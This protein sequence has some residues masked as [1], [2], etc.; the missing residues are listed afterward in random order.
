MKSVHRRILFAFLCVCL[1]SP[2]LIAQDLAQ[3]ASRVSELWQFRQQGNRV[4]TL[5]LIE[6]QTQNEFLQANDSPIISFKISAIEFTD[7]DPNQLN[8]VVKVRSA[9][10]QLGEVDR[11]VRETWV[12]KDG[13]WLMRYTPAPRGIFDSSTENRPATPGLPEFKLVNSVIDVGRHAQGALVEGKIPFQAKR[14]ELVVIRPIQNLPGLS[15]S[16]PFWTSA[17]EG[18]LSFQWETTL[19]SKN[20]DQTIDLEAI[21][22]SETRVSATIRFRARIDGKIG[23]T[24]VPEV[25][26]PA[27]AGKVEL[28]IENLT[29]KPLKMLSVI[30]QNRAYVVD[31]NVPELI[32]PG[33]SGR[34]LI[35]YSAQPQPAG[36]SLALAF[37]EPISTSGTIRV[38]LNIRLGD[39]ARPRSY[40]PQELKKLVSPAPALPPGR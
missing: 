7:D 29:A 30:S 11:S 4:G 8:V 33:K 31:E 15:I 27:K 21:A 23:F 12:W 35:N 25:I 9:V 20:V 24:Q 40:T 16:S 5:S 3:L 10:A 28:V 6:P 22:T 1:S 32:A 18:Y 37:S 17:S 2:Y 14:G 36:A 19:L 34:L 26:D 13:K 38:P 39:E